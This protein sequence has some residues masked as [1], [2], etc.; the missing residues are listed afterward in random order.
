MVDQDFAGLTAINGTNWAYTFGVC[1]GSQTYAHS[2]VYDPANHDLYVACEGSSNYVAAV[3]PGTGTVVATVAVPT[4]LVLAFDPADNDIYVGSGNSGST[5]SPVSVISGATNQVVATIA[6]SLSGPNIPNQIIYNPANNDLYITNDNA[7]NYLTVINGATNAFV[8]NVQLATVGGGTAGA[9]VYD[10]SNGD[11]YVHAPL[12]A[13]TDSVEAVSTSNVV[14]AQV[15]PGCGGGGDEPQFAYNSK[16]GNVYCGRVYTP[17]SGPS[18]NQVCAISSTP[19]SYVGCVTTST[20]GSLGLYGQSYL[21]YDPANNDIYVAG[22]GPDNSSFAPPPETIE[23]VSSS[24]VLLQTIAIPGVPF[25]LTFDP[26]NSEVC[27]GVPQ[28]GSPQ[29]NIVVPLSS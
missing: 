22:G 21:V 14:V 16:N 9:A 4:P 2:G 6:G 12:Q 10:P 18:Y 25:Q 3:N 29:F 7:P 27:A 28:T 5:I 24:L 19:I 11:V 17:Q 20:G 23:V 1:T 8:T 26:A 13:G 15:T